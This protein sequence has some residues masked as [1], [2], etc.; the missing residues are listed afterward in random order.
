MLIQNGLILSFFSTKVDALA[1]DMD[2]QLVLNFNLRKSSNSLTGLGYYIINFFAR[3]FAFRFSWTEISILEC[4]R[5][6]PFSNN[7]SQPK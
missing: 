3:A 5:L 4:L 6:R 2:R 1:I 7:F